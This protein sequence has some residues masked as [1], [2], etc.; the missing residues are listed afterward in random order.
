MLEI[1]LDSQRNAST[2]CGWKAK[3]DDQRRTIAN[4]LK[5]GS[6]LP[7]YKTDKG[8]YFTPSSASMVDIDPYLRA[9]MASCLVLRNIFALPIDKQ[10]SDETIS[11]INDFD[12]VI[13]DCPPTLGPITL[14]AMCVSTGLI[15]PAQLEAFS[16]R[17]LGN[18]IAKFKEV[19][20]NFNQQL[21]IRG[22]L[23]VMTDARPLITQ[24]YKESLR[25]TFTDLVFN[26]MI[27]RNIRIVESQDY[28]GPDRLLSASSHFLWRSL[29]A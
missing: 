14:N 27:R 8:L 1:D 13:I 20:T 4:A 21:T 23:F 19:Q 22:L 10:F 15:I 17:G 16:V 9:N 7:V 24:A 3:K 11:T 12:Y 25:E 5:E 26:S 28:E 6:P 29:L 2:L 18:V